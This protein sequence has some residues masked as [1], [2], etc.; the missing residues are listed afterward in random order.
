MIPKEE[1]SLARRVG[2]VS[3]YIITESNYQGITRTTVQPISELGKEK[4]KIWKQL[5]NFTR[6]V[7]PTLK[8]NGTITNQNDTF[9]LQD[10]EWYDEVPF[11]L[12][13]SGVRLIDDHLGDVYYVPV[14]AKIVQPITRCMVPETSAK[15]KRD[16]ESRGIR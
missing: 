9:S 10:E 11:E 3:C 15:R 6:E 2:T 1:F 14:G 12:K 7:N 4:S 8:N 5:N 13:K 16:N